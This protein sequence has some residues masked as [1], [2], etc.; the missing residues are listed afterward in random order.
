MPSLLAGGNG[1]RRAYP[2][3]SQ[4]QGIS[5]G[6]EGEGGEEGPVWPQVH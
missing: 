6:M 1:R 2:C 5:G 3:K 4:E